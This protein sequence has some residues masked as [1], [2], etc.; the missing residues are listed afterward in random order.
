VGVYREIG[1][2]N[3]AW[4]DVAWLQ[5]MLADGDTPPADPIP[6]LGTPGQTV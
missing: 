4:H 3:G 6:P 2:K 1:Y 5:L